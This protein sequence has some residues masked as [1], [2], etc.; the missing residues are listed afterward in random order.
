MSYKGASKNEKVCSECR[1]TYWT[2][3]PQ[4]KCCSRECASARHRRKSME[5]FHTWKKD[6][7]EIQSRA[8]KYCGESFLPNRHNRLFC[9]SRCSH[10][11]KHRLRREM[12]KEPYRGDVA[13]KP[14]GEVKLPPGS[15]GSISEL[16]VCSDILSKGWYAFHSVTPNGPCDVI[17]LVGTRAVRVE[18]R[19]GGGKRRNIPRHLFDVLAIVNYR[20]GSVLYRPPLETFLPTS[21]Q[22]LAQSAPTT[23]PSQSP[24][25]PHLECA[26]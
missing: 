24:V 15:I 18:V 23:S 9:T 14:S 17:A 16:F 1:T 26:S 21:T 12:F 19:T 11:Y 8:C 3:Y 2:Q 4:S 10:T 7:P 6:K 22:P 13:L 25:Q 20:D 5:D